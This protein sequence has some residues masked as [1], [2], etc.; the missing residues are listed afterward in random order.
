MPDDTGTGY[1][2]IQVRDVIRFTPNE[3][4]RRKWT[5]RARDERYIIATCP[6]PFRPKGERWYTVVD[7][8]GWTDKKYNGAG[9]GPVRSSLDEA[10]GG[11]P[12]DVDAL[13]DEGCA[14]ILSRLQ[15]GES[16]LS[17]RRV[18]NVW[19][20]TVVGV[21]AT[22]EVSVRRTTAPTDGR[23][24]HEFDQPTPGE[25]QY[26][27]AS[28]HKTG[29]GVTYAKVLPEHVAIIAAAV[30]RGQTHPRIAE[31]W[32]ERRVYGSEWE[33]VDPSVAVLDTEARA[34]QAI[35]QHI[36]ERDGRLS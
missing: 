5:V 7:L 32:L 23:S 14:T 12:L 16:D 28:T 35:V 21:A 18:V 36:A 13:D 4:G 3:D 8:T 9:H 26:R 20:I 11:L 19:G 29:P 34:D 30:A 15:S 10:G 24:W 25:V 2:Q 31:N 27:L 17:H 6:A 22:R 33:R 1:E